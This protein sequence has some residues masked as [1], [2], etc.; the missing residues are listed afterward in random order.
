M[1]SND[2]VPHGCSLTI[3]ALRDGCKGCDQCDESNSWEPLR[4]EHVGLLE[5]FHLHQLCDWKSDTDF[6]NDSLV[7]DLHRKIEQAHAQL[8]GTVTA[9][10]VGATASAAAGTTTNGNVASNGDIALQVG[11]DISNCLREILETLQRRSSSCGT[12]PAN[13]EEEEE[14]ID[15]PNSDKRRTAP[16]VDGSGQ[17]ET[18]GKEPRTK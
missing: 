6:M 11:M 15:D 10:H 1:E 8:K 16:D 14:P 2:V 12:I 7:V 9:R 3:C 13:P 17:T 5:T 18:G 4:N